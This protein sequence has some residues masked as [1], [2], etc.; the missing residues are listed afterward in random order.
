LAPAAASREDPDMAFRAVLFDFY[1]TL[2]RAT[3][4]RSADEVLAE[5][6]YTLPAEARD[7][8]FNDGIDGMEHLEQS[9]SREH[10]MA[11]QRERTLA[12]LA[13]SDVHPDEYETIVR[14]LREGA[15]QRVLE[16]YG[17]V[18]SVLSRLRT[19]GLRLAICSNWDWDLAEAVDDTKLTEFF[20]VQVSSAWAGARK[21]HPRIFRRTLGELGAAPPECL[22][23]GDS[24]GPDV[25]GPRAVGLPSVYLRRSGHWF[26]PGAPENPGEGDVVAVLPD[27][28]GIV[29]LV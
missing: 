23:V 16:A 25:E 22:F 9:R 2:A 24:W 10:Y 17:E 19:R 4:W 11:W 27:L 15:T 3:Q 18:P 7:R 28:E 29:D 20:E 26:D 21:P 14:K 5:H 1:G 8:W 12:M 6:G 13:E